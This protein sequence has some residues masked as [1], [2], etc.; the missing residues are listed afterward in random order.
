LIHEALPSL[1]RSKHEYKHVITISSLLARVGFRRHAA[2]CA[3][4]AGLL[5]LTRALAV[6]LAPEQILVNAISP[7]IVR[8]GMSVRLA[9]TVMKKHRLTED[10]SYAAIGKGLPLGK[11][12][13]PEEIA[14]VI[15]FLISDQQVS[16]TGQSFEINNGALMP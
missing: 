4:K 16:M 14:G 3:S 8:G 5:G 15:A 6:E 9:R 12:C 11:V 1:R 10:S 7:G 13:E 2:Y